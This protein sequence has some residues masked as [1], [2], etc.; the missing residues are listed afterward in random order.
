[1]ASRIPDDNAPLP[2]DEKC[3][4]GKL[5]NGMTYYVQSNKKPA[6]RAELRLVVKVGSVNESEEEQG[7]AHIVEHLAFRGTQ[8]YD[9]FEVVRFLEAI[10]AR[11]GACQNAYTAFDETVYYLHVPI[12]TEGLLEQSL[13]V[14]REWAFNVRCSAEDVEKERGVVLEEWRQG[15]TAHGR[16]DEDYVTT[17]MD[18]SQYAKRLP[19]GKLEVIEKCAPGLVR[20]FYERWYH[21]QR[22]AVMAVGDFDAFA[23][24][25]PRVVEM[26]RTLF[27]VQPKHPFTAPV[28]VPFPSHDAPRLSVFSDPEA[29]GTS[30]SVDCKR[31]RQDVK[32]HA[33]YRRT[34]RE[35]LF[36]EA[37]SSRLYKMAVSPDPPFF[38]AVTSLSFPTSIMETC[39]LGVSVQEGQELAGL[40][41]TLLEV[42][43]V[44]KFGFQ[45]EELNRAKANLLSD[46]EADHREHDQLESDGF[47]SEFVEHFCRNEPAMG[48][49]YEV[50]LCRAILPSITKEEVAGVVKDYHWD[51]NCVVKITRP[52]TSWMKRMFG[53]G[54]KDIAEEDMQ[55]VL[56]R[57][58]RQREA[59]V[60]W[61]HSPVASFADILRPPPTP[62]KIVT[63]T[64]Y[65]GADVWEVMLSNGIRVTYKKTNFLDDEVQMKTFA[66][67][68]LS[69]LS[70]SLLLAGRMSTSLAS[71]VGVFGLP[72]ADVV[73]M[74]AGKRVSMNFQIGCYTRALAA[75][76]SPTDLEAALQMLHLLFVS[77]IHP[78]PG[79]VAMLMA[80]MR[81]QVRNQHRSPEALFAQRVQAINTGGA[82]F[83]SPITEQDIDS[84][85]THLA[86]A[87][88]RSAFSNP[89]A[90]TLV[91]SGNLD[92]KVLLP[93]LE[94]YIASIP[95]GLNP[96]PTQPPLPP[97]PANKDDLKPVAYKF[98]AKGV[99][100]RLRLWLVDPLCCSQITFPLEMAGEGGEEEERGTLLLSHSLQVLQSRLV[101]RLRFQHSATY[102]VSADADLS[103]SH[104]SKRYPLSGTIAISYACRPE[105]IRS[106][107]GL[108]LRELAALKNEGPTQKE[109]ETRQE[110]SR[111]E[112]ETSSK[113]NTWWVDR[114]ASSYCAR[115]NHGDVDESLKHFEHLRQSVLSELSPSVLQAVF[116]KHFPDLQRHTLVTLEPSLASS[117]TA[118]LARPSLVTALL[119][120]ASLAAAGTLL[121]IGLRAARRRG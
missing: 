25:A 121:L 13:T 73:D 11:F 64:H 86:C 65:P 116:R 72:P 12:D 95:P 8:L 45:E 90:F 92:D 14:L 82:E 62:G 26:I 105:H 20:G 112:H 60:P 113:Y 37:L 84:I 111:R 18:G 3:L 1:M 109:V 78:E 103:T 114:I 68:G 21:P 16:T 7:V 70:S 28:A 102:T 83:F 46:L 77:D 29:T 118:L 96:P 106:L 36:H 39:V 32:N 19:I 24:G 91:L 79:K 85:D 22:M 97:V 33:D 87:Y 40:E 108:V 81:D 10:G 5:E 100:D 15:R 115:I 2:L 61:D 80:M 88:F 17:L 57:L 53:K 120:S 101:E 99:Q 98:P 23:D 59:L 58:E 9:T 30:V 110:I 38:S 41:A 34:I 31:P 67:G 44:R 48:V 93:A 76:C 117:L 104:P 50:D 54:G 107:S 66:F 55:R 49:K 47:C 35:H 75:E 42:E 51:R 52:Q 119:L 6:A 56:A 74:M 94:K 63:K 43:R 27:D 89:A 71:E 69:E 4:Y